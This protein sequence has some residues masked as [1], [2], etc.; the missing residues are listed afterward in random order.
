M[1]DNSILDWLLNPQG[2]WYQMQ[3]DPY[4]AQVQMGQ[5][6]KPWETAPLEVRQ[7]PAADER[8]RQMMLSSRL[9]I[10]RQFGQ[11]REQ[12]TEQYA[13]RGLGRAGLQGALAPLYQQEMGAV[14]Q[15]LGQIGQQK[16]AE[17]AQ[18]AQAY[19]NFRRAQHM[20]MEQG[21]WGRTAQTAGES[22]ES[23]LNMALRDWAEQQKEA[24]EGW[25]GADMMQGIIKLALSAYGG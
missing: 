1:A 13:G 21:L 5:M 6:L 4:G 14:A 23:R 22:W 24:S 9:G 16:M 7:D 12:A 25:G 8:Y 17:E 18:R 10:G 20:G 11:A 2:N 15:A 19:M 3:Q